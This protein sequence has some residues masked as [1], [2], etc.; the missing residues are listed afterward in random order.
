M[1]IYIYRYRPLFMI[2]EKVVLN[3]RPVFVIHMTQLVR[4]H[5]RSTQ[6]Q[7]I[8]PILADFGVTGLLISLYHFQCGRD[9]A[10]HQQ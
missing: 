3:C 2:V 7:F 5:N 4:K 6:K 10:Q 1:Y 9:M 8:Y